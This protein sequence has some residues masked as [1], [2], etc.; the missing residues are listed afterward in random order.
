MADEKKTNVNNEEAVNK[1]I[2]L[3]DLENVSGGSIGNV[4]YTQTTNISPDT[5]RKA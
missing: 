2:N 1:E 5:K 3:D 4:S